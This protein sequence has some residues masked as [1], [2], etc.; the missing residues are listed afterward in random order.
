MRFASK[1]QLQKLKDSGVALPKL[2]NSL[3]FQVSR[4]IQNKRKLEFGRN[5]DTFNPIKNKKFEVLRQN[6]RFR[7]EAHK[8]AKNVKKFQSKQ[9]IE[10]FMNQLKKEQD[11]EN[12]KNNESFQSEQLDESEIE[13][14]NLEKLRNESEFLRPI[15]LESNFDRFEYLKAGQFNESGLEKQLKEKILA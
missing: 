15:K 1:K 6:R 3:Q 4:F 11:K 13:R 8:R 7:R 5:L 10:N 2:D 9:D 14:N 12:Y